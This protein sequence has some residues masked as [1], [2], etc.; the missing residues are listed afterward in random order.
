M[1]GERHGRVAAVEGEEL[2]AEFREVDFLGVGAA[3]GVCGRIMLTVDLLGGFLRTVYL[4]L[5]PWC[6]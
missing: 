2:G 4:L 5:E 1:R 3:V 6:V